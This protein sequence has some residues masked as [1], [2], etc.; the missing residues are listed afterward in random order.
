MRWRFGDLSVASDIPFPGLPA[1]DGAADVVVRRGTIAT[2]GW[3]PVQ[4]WT[5]GDGAADW[6]VIDRGHAGY[7]LRFSDLHCAISADGSLIEY[8]VS[9]ASGDEIVHLLLHQVLPLAAS[10]TGRLVVHA[11]GMQTPRGI[12]AVVGGS[13]AGKSTLA[14]AFCRRGA[15]LVAD[16]ALVM[17]QGPGETRAWPTADGLRVWDD[18]AVMMPPGI[19]TSVAEGRK[20]RIRVRV[21]TEDQEVRRL[22]FFGET[23][24][25]GVHLATV[26]PESARVELLSNLFRLDIADAVESRRLFEAVHALAVSVPL[27]RLS[28]PDGVEHLDAVVDAVLADLDVA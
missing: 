10:R 13:G 24:E 22:L 4:A 28:Y 12:V 7:R 25:S 3:T 11:C 2:S 19:E 6:L 1:A 14:A 18:I 27:R 20:V 8:D 17:T 21:A 5:A 15:A 26:P 16:D 23:R 9:T